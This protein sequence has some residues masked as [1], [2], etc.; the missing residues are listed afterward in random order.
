MSQHDV[1]LA[2]GISPRHMSFIET[3]RAQP[4]REVLSV[5]SLA[6]GIPSRERNLVLQAAGYAPMYPSTRFD[7]PEM[8]AAQTALKLMLR[9]QEPF[10]AVV[11][12][13]QWD[14]LMV[15]Q[16]M[17]RFLAAAG[18]KKMPAPYQIA[19]T[20]RSNWL[21]TLLAPGAI[22]AL[23]INWSEVAEALLLRANRELWTD[24]ER[25]PLLRE[26]STYPG[27]PTPSP[28]RMNDPVLL[29]PI[30]LRL[31]KKELRLFSTVS[32]LGTAQDV[33]LQELKID[34]FHPLDESQL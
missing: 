16:A 21:K 30:R 18:Q 27:V 24:P 5:V 7:A 34:T 19:R 2:A 17:H 23:L 6:L 13:R 26:V 11:I 28:L 8:S 12:D 14:I 20:A 4:S 3:G 15:N 10:G 32:S 1:A 29:I 9:R 31:G 22:R 33:T 25:E